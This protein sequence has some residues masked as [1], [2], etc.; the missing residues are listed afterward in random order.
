VRLAGRVVAAGF[1][2]G[3]G[4]DL[5][6]GEEWHHNRLTLVS[7]MQGWGAPSRFSGWDRPRLRAA[8]LELLA[9][10][11]LARDGLVSHRFPFADAADAYRLLAERPTEALRVL[12]VYDAA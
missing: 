2:A 4:A 12:L 10:G 8:A 5:R 1:Y 7:S 3:G 6:L 11:R 9:D